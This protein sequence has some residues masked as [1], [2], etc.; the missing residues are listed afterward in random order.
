MNF[1]YTADTAVNIDGVSHLIRM[2]NGMTGIGSRQYYID[3]ERQYL[4]CVLHTP[5][6]TH[7]EREIYRIKWR[8]TPWDLVDIIISKDCVPELLADER[9]W[10]EPTKREFRR[11]S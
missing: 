2:E 7:G 3:G 4:H 11:P 5:D 9:K 10:M 6:L 1:E 8:D